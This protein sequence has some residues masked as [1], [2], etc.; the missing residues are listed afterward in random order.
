MLIFTFFPLI[1]SGI[2]YASDNAGNSYV[3]CLTLCVSAMTVTGLN[4]ILMETLSH[5]QQ[6][7]IFFLCCVGSTVCH[8]Y[9]RLLMHCDADPRFAFK[10]FFRAESRLSRSSSDVTSFASD[11][12]IWSRLIRELAS[13]YKTLR[14]PR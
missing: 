12:S 4:P 14:L 1:I 6:A 10:M 3:D 9:N 11:S 7:I 5:W 2:F 8:A 13:V